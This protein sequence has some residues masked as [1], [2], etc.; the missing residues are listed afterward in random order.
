MPPYLCLPLLACLLYP[1]P[2]LFDALPSPQ[3]PRRPP[4]PSPSP[5][6]AFPSP[7][8][9]RGP[10]CPSLL[11]SVN[12]EHTIISRTAALLRSP[13]SAATFSLFP[14]LTRPASRTASARP[15]TTKGN[16][17]PLVDEIATR[18]REKTLHS[19]L[20]NTTREGSGEEGKRN[21]AEREDGDRKEGN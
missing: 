21:K 7:I 10:P 2:H 19:R 17:R 6:S 11:L 12:Q 9:T 13:S 8:P 3:H 18:Q 4:H 16:S 15:S 1:S 20:P 5:S 14:V